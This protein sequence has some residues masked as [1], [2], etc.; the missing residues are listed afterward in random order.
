MSRDKVQLAACAIILL[1]LPCR[2]IDG[3][4]ILGLFST[5]SPSHLVVHMAMMRALADRGHNVTIV[6]AIKPRLVPHENITLILAPMSEAT[7]AEVNQFME[8]STKEKPSMNGIFYRMLIKAAVMLDCQYEFLLHPNVR[9]IYERPQTKFDLLFLGFMFNDYQ[10]GVAAKLGIPAVISWVGVPFTF[11][12]DE[13]GN[14]Y[15]PAYVPNLKVGV[16][17]SQRA[18]DFGQRLKNYCTWVF[19]KT[20]AFILDRR[21]ENYYNGAFGADLQ[22]P[23]YWDARRNISLLFYNYHS[24]SEGPVRPTVPQSI[25]VGGVQIKEQPDP[26]PSEL[27]EFLDNAKAGAIFFSLGTNVKSGYFTPNVMEAFFKVLSSQP[28][29]VIWKWDDLQHT[30]GNASNI[31]YHNWLPQ[32]DI[33]AHPNTKLFI[34]HAGKGGIA[35]AQYHGVPM[36]AMPIFGDQHG[37]ADNMVYAGFGLSVDWTTL[38]E[39]SLAQTLNEV[40]Q[41]ASY[42]ERVRSF[43]ALYRDRPLTARQ[44][45]VYWTEYVLRHKGAYHLQNPALHLA[46]VARHNLDVYACLLI[47]LAVSLTLLKLLLRCIWQQLR[48]L[49]PSK[50][51]VKRQ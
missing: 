44:S 30:P 22:M 42:R 35:E 50:D 46:F 14:I 12:D 43:S 27:A 39:A 32:D 4:N 33:L 29:R 10:L 3:A 18:M 45:V 26:L 48:T 37:N 13:V 49:A 5:F 31:Y 15:D 7:L 1:V 25:E 9:A 24:H 51:K 36:V 19:L 47:L 41:N 6:S 21:M 38:T 2:P 34:T 11:I 20:I 8:S 23:S 17:S 28:L 40:L 16:A